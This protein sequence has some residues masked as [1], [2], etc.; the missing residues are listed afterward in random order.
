MSGESRRLSC[1]RAQRHS[2]NCVQYLTMDAPD[3]Q[4]NGGLT[5]SWPCSG[6]PIFFQ[7]GHLLCTEWNGYMQA[8]RLT[9]QGLDLVAGYNSKAS[10]VLGHEF[11]GM[12]RRS[13]AASYWAGVE[14]S[15][16]N[17]CWMR[18]LRGLPLQGILPLSRLGLPGYCQ[19]RW[20]LCRLSSPAHRESACRSRSAGRYLTM[21]L[22][23]P[24]AALRIQEQLTLSL[25]GCGRVERA[26]V[27]PWPRV[28]WSPL[29]T[30]CRQ[31]QIPSCGGT[32]VNVEV[33]CQDTG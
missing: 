14:G 19:P 12:V 17:Q 5:V 13:P 3:S 26:S 1:D 27:V 4:K 29:V 16:R 11:V 23:E 8:L 9:Q 25:P 18:R 20:C 28:A 7:C 6:I 24:V 31:P 33:R 32:V 2:K 30:A 15:G 21:V 10:L 22:I